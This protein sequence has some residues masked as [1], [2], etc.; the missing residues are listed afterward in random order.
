MFRMGN[1]GRGCKGRQRKD[2]A[3]FGDAK[4]SEEQGGL[5][6]YRRV[7]HIYGNANGTLPV[8]PTSLLLPSSSLSAEANNVR[9]RGHDSTLQL[10]RNLIHLDLKVKTCGVARDWGLKGKGGV[11]EWEV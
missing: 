8:P 6:S 11:L 7:W 4:A 9:S 3:F 5:P 1:M 2:T 10:G